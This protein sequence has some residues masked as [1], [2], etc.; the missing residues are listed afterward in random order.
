MRAARPHRLL[1]TALLTLGLL[2]APGL[3]AAGAGGRLPLQEPPRPRRQAVVSLEDFH[4]ALDPLGT[5]FVHPRWGQVWKPTGVSNLWRPYT[6]GRWA[7]TD[8][9]WY[10]VSEEPW[11]WATY[12]FG[13][14]FL[15]PLTGWLWAPGKRW[16]PAWVQW[17]EGKGI[18]GWA[19]LGPDGKALAMHYT[20]V[21][22]GKLE[23]PAD[24][25][26]LPAPRTGEALRDTR[27]VGAQ[28]QASR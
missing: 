5:W 19:P 9:T 27:P 12:H 11:A 24:E 15:D 14:W 7:R 25:V 20:F 13:R 22:A 18:A 16:A 17:R 26:A 23:E 6:R 1:A 28:A 8:G 10:W 3:A 4:A 21:P 2:A